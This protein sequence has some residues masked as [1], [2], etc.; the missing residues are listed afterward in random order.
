[1]ATTVAR[2]EA[3]L[4]A[5]TKG[6]DR[7][8][9]R[10]ETRMKKVGTAA[11]IGLGVGVA[12][13]I[14]VLKSSIG[15]AMEAEKAE[16]RLGQAFDSVKASAKARQTAQEAVNRVSKRAAL[17]DEDLSDVLAKLTRSTGSVKEATDAMALSA[18]IARG[19]NVSLEQ[20]AKAVERAHLGQETGLRRL[21]VVVPEVTD[22]QD[23]L[24]L[25]IDAVREAIKNA[26]GPQ[27]RILQEQ[28]KELEGH[29]KLA[30]EM[31]ARKTKQEV[32][33]EAQRQFAGSS[34]RYGQTAAGAQ[35]RVRVAVEN[36]QEAIG[37]KL[38]PQLTPLINKLAEL[39]EDTATFIDKLQGVDKW[40]GK[41]G[42]N[43][44]LIDILKDFD[45]KTKDIVGRDYS[46]IDFFKDLYKWTNRWN[47]AMDKA[48]GL[49][50]DLLGGGRGL[51][52]LIG[53]ATGDA[54]PDRWLGNFMGG[55]GPGSVSPALYDE[56]QGARNM[57][58]VLTSGYRPGAITKH[59]T[60]SD[61]GVFPS[62]AIDVSG[63]SGQMAAYFRWLIGQR[64]V[65]Q[66]FYDPLGSI[67][68]GVLSNYRE[69]GHRDH[70]HVATYDQ[71]G[72]KMLRKGWNMIGNFTGSPE[73]VYATGRGGGAPVNIYLTNQGIL[74]SER[75]VE[76]WL[77]NAA[78]K[79]RNRGGTL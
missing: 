48:R 41:I 58:L 35:D 1:M 78:A 43:Q 69:G 10:S 12:A 64:D 38:L 27:K 34:E 18:E 63:S 65:K 14:A 77:Q 45:E 51:K 17:D 28:L 8:M 5:D 25:Q 39:T 72:W 71:A 13:G 67:F 68:G 2:L 57:G 62:K 75:E 74:G 23:K 11:K 29:K 59:G 4:T 76:R 40:M 49:F 6:F 70:V 37:K 36:L 30:K 15:A 32:L 3:L 79:I 54:D 7:A 19:R 46:L 61:H 42:A 20:A 33:S 44:G 50:A 9:S 60:P 73:P 66:A 21:G 52:D 24:K 26:E 22:A 56:L 53:D 47:E 16:M 55:T 31:D